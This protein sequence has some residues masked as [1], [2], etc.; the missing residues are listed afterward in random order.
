MR[1][2][3]ID[4]GNVES[5]IA[6][7]DGERCEFLKTGNDNLILTLHKWITEKRPDMIYIEGMQS[8]GMAV[9][10]S[11]FETAYFIGQIQMWKQLS[12]YHV[13]MEM[14]FRKDVKIHHCNSMK[15]KDGNIRQALIDRFGEPG[16]KN[17]PGLLYKCSKDMWSAVAIAVMGYDRLTQNAPAK[18]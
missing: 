6:Y 12:H 14:I 13:K 1:I 11:V 10:Q 18:E 7:F 8:F 17:N 4:P 5:A 15:A 3:G 2:I 16:T 9:G